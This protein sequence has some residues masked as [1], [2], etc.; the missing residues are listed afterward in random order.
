[1]AFKFNP[2]T[3]KFDIAG[4]GG[5]G[6]GD[7]FLVDVFTITAP[8]AAAKEV[9]LTDTPTSAASTLALLGGIAQTPNV[10]F[11]VSGNVLSWDSLGMDA[12]PVEAGDI[13][14]VIYG[15]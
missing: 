10:D 13:L 2:F 11:S 8:Q 5:G 6:G 7:T 4:S 3:G 15:A 14:V 1:M 9:T 12:L